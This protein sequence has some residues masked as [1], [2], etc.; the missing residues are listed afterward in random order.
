MTT[1]SYE[2]TRSGTWTAGGERITNGTSRVE[3]SRE[4]P[5][6]LLQEYARLAVRGAELSHRDD[7]TWFAEIP[8]FEGVWASGASHTEALDA[9]EEVVFDWAILKIRHE[10]RDLPVIESI[11]LNEL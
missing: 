3:T 6:N 10:D 11:D 7:G 8:G 5:P 2:R 1:F 9:L 4:L